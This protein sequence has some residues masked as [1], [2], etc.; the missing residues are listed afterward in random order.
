M[1]L[2]SSLS[3]EWITHKKTRRA[4]GLLTRVNWIHL[5]IEGRDGGRAASKW[6]QNTRAA[7]NA[8]AA[9]KLAV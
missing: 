2:E 5:D 1:S 8:S 3:G 4:V 6:N 9:Q 7:R